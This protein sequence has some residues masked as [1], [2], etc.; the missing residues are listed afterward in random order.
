MERTADAPLCAKRLIAA[1]RCCVAPAAGKARGIDP[2]A[3][4]DAP[5]AR[6]RAN[7]RSSCRSS[8]C[9]WDCCRTST[10]N[11]G[12]GRGTSN[13]RTEYR[14]NEVH[15]IHVADHGSATESASSQRTKE[16]DHDGVDYGSAGNC[17]SFWNDT[18]V[19]NSLCGLCL[20]ALRHGPG[21]TREEIHGK[22]LYPRRDRKREIPLNVVRC[23]P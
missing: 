13:G 11:R 6:S 10:R 18:L 4:T 17:P 12:C 14:S 9:R 3:A 16:P 21:C 15:E 1:T 20:P 19:R 23:P 22:K 2:A 5:L 7:S 8:G